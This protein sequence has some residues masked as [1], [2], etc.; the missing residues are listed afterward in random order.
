ME[1]NIVEGTGS[2]E[3]ENLR[4]KIKAARDEIEAAMKALVFLFL[5]I[6]GILT[7]KHAFPGHCDVILCNNLMVGLLIA[8]LALGIILFTINTISP[9][10]QETKREK[11]IVAVFTHI[12]ALIITVPLI[13]ATVYLLVAKSNNL[14]ELTFISG[15]LGV[16]VGF[17][18]GHR[19]VESAES[20]RDDVESQAKVHWE[21]KVE[22]EKEILTTKL[23]AEK[24]H[25]ENREK[26]N[27]DQYHIKEL[28]DELN[29]HK[30]DAK[31]EPF[32]KFWDRFKEVAKKRIEKVKKI[33]LEKID[34]YR[35]GGGRKLWKVGVMGKK[36]SLRGLKRSGNYMIWI[37][38]KR[39][40]VL[41]KKLKNVLKSLKR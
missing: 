41:K 9:R 7:L 3:H 18:F 19:G 23:D 11:S 12:I 22:A 26:M 1:A 21:A 14:E 16:I 37:K 38:R 34:R 33:D 35:R 17:Y 30:K 5:I 31:F 13:I 40:I 6:F 39:G 25:E 8:I 15:L 27:D 10:S 36:G 2:N 24:K 4:D 28:K 20:R 29:R 32:M